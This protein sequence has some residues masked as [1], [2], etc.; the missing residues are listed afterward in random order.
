MRHN[1]RNKKGFTLTELVVLVAVGAILTGT[2]LPSLSEDRQKMLQAACASNLKQWG[3]V[4]QLY[5]DDF[6]G[7]INVMLPA[8]AYGE[9]YRVV[10][11]YRMYFCGTGGYNDCVGGTMGPLSQFRIL[12]MKMCP[13]QIITGGVS[14]NTLPGYSMIRPNPPTPN[15]RAWCLKN[16]AHPSSMAIMIDANSLPSGFIGPNAAGEAGAGGIMQVMPAISRH[17][18]G[19]NIL[20]ADMHVTWEAWPAILA[21]I[22]TGFDGP[23][24][25]LMVPPCMDSFIPGSCGYEIGNQRSCH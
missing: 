5:A 7:T 22:G 25:N 1:Q 23:W 17:F 9:W 4:F 6:N 21:G 19:C 15:F 12:K 16:C 18:G 11:P 13:A 2:L 24:A 8:N 3:M 14:D 20:W 10:G